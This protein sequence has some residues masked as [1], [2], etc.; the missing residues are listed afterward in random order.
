[1]KKFSNAKMKEIRQAIEKTLEER[2]TEHWCFYQECIALSSYA[3]VG[4]ENEVIQL[5]DN[6]KDAVLSQDDAINLIQAIIDKK[7]SSN[8]WAHLYN[9]KKRRDLCSSKVAQYLLSQYATEK[10][11][12]E[13]MFL[14]VD[15]G[16]ASD[17][18]KDIIF[19]I[20]KRKISEKLL[21]HIFSKP[22]T[23]ELDEVLIQAFVDGAIS[24]KLMRTI[25][26]SDVSWT[27]IALR[28]MFGSKIDFLVEF[29]LKKYYPEINI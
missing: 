24:E 22:C 15:S 3:L 7:I 27:E 19:F 10:I 1:M 21:F 14:I 23:F 29:Y 9:G 26:S 8:V 11:A 25:L 6:D 2:A 5:L 4:K 13:T 12:D 16:Y 18:L 20:S 28:N 17:Y